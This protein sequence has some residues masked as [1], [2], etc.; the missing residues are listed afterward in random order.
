MWIRGGMNRHE[1]AEHVCSRLLHPEAD[2][3]P[4]LVVSV[5]SQSGENATDGI[6]NVGQNIPKP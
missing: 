4:E 6:L 1:H 5:T 3:S 2:P